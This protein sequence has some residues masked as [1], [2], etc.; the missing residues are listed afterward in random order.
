MSAGQFRF[1]LACKGVKASA[2]F[3][4]EDGHVWLG[5]TQ[6][7]CSSG[8][9]AVVL[10]NEPDIFPDSKSPF[11]SRAWTGFTWDSME[12]YSA[13]YCS[14]CNCMHDPYSHKFYLCMIHF[15]KLEP[16]LEPKLEP[17]VHT[18]YCTNLSN[19][20]AGNR[21]QSV[22][23]TFMNFAQ[24]LDRFLRIFYWLAGRKVSQFWQ[25]VSRSSVLWARSN[26]L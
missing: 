8:M 4:G 22:F 16:N 18:L 5:C 9:D 25:I 19:G 12:S 3:D 20:T 2:E 10:D 23:A 13:G 15:V 14:D 6:R 1:C 11:V 26:D 21:C 7:E 24:S 17:N